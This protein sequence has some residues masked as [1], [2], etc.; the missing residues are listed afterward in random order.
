[1]WLN[2]SPKHAPRSIIRDLFFHI[3]NNTWC[4][5]PF[6]VCWHD[7]HKMMFHCCFNLNFFNLLVR[8]RI[9]YMCIYIMCVCIYHIYVYTCVYIR[10]CT[11]VY[12]YICIFLIFTADGILSNEC[13][14]KILPLICFTPP[15]FEYVKQY[16]CKHSC[17]CLWAHTRMSFSRDY[18]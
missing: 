17:T 5:Q 8:L 6:N 9:I 16:H 13:F 1:M 18:I 15:V 3:L 14:T 4:C 7:V 12:I 10:I 2:C 11:H